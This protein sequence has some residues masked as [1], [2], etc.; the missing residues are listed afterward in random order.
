[1]SLNVI[2]LIKGQITPELIGKL[3]SNLGENESGISKA[4]SGLL[5]SVLS[6]LSDHSSN[7]SVI[8]AVMSPET[9]NYLNF[10]SL[11]GSGRSNTVISGI[12]KTIFGDKLNGVLETIANFSG[13]DVS[14]IGSLLDVVTGAALGSVSKLVSDRNLNRD[15]VVS[16]LNHQ[17]DHISALLPAGL[18]LG[19]LGLGGVSAKLDSIKNDISE[20][21][22]DTKE[23]VTE[24]I[25]ES[26]EDKGGS[27]LKWLVPLLLAA[28]AIWFLFK[29]CKKDETVT[30]TTTTTTTVIRELTDV[31]LN[32]TKLRAYPDG[33]E[34]RLIVFLKDGYAVATEETLKDM[35]YDF[36]NVEFVF[37]KSDEVMPESKGQ[38]ENLAA[39]LKAYPDAKI[40]IGG[41]T[42]KV[43]DEEANKK[44]SDE[45]AEFIKSELTK[46]GVGNQ[47][48]DAEGYGEEFAV[49][50]ENASDEERAKDRRMSVRFVK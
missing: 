12:I 48:V 4:I 3:S 13:V 42:D 44:L 35:W 43:G 26:S 22:V 16:L 23:K 47:V 50:D 7:P 1:M 14:K 25:N 36:D 31:D 38:L 10:D 49:V 11:L 34:S 24:V 41:Y 8:D 6:G 17:E 15:Q 2:E 37:G 9:K 33:L 29:K 39:I 21:L 20:K 46:L 40:K 30:T 5:P 27:F 18:T 19:V 32:G 45:R 28:L